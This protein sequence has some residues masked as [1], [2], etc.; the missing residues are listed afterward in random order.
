[1]K[2]IVGELHEASEA[3]TNWERNYDSTI[4]SLQ[5]QTKEYAD[6]KKKCAEVQSFYN[7]L[8]KEKKEKDDY[9]KKAGKNYKPTKQDEI[10][11]AVYKRASKAYEANSFPHTVENC[12]GHDQWSNK[13]LSGWL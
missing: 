6:W 1:V 7:E 11:D 13:Q 12:G 2:S 10:F 3:L 5:M 9:R 4:L 8:T